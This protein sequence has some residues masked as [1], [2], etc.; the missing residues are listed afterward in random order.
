VDKVPLKQFGWSRLFPTE[1]CLARFTDFCFYDGMLVFSTLPLTHINSFNL[2]S[3][4]TLKTVVDMR[5]MPLFQIADANTSL[6]TNVSLFVA[7]EPTQTFEVLIDVVIPVFL[8]FSRNRS[9]SIVLLKNQT[10]LVKNLEPFDFEIMYYNTSERRCFSA[11]RFLRSSN[12]TSPYLNHHTDEDQIQ[13]VLDML[14]NFSVAELRRL[15]TNSSL[16]STFV[17][18]DAQAKQELPNFE[19]EEMPDTDDL[20]IIADSVARAAHFLVSDVRSLMFALFMN[21]HGRISYRDEE[22][23][24]MVAQ[25]GCLV[26]C[27]FGLGIP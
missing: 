24:P 13:F 7:A 16:E 22:M 19:C 3:N 10:S 2:S 18:C 27:E 4:F 8:A 25:I 20:R 23:A 15:Y 12:S 9:N 14:S 17:L 21:E 6:T 26:H 1:K 5:P 11:G